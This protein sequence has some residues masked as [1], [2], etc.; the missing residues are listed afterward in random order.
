MQLK[1]CIA[2]RLHLFFRFI[3]NSDTWF[4]LCSLQ[5]VK[6]SFLVEDVLMVTYTGQ[7][8]A[9]HADQLSTGTVHERDST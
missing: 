7:S 8:Q 9:A 4:S 3:H 1:R 6:L 2:L 5:K